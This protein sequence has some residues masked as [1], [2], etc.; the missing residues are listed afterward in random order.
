MR[1]SR[2]W[3]RGAFLISATLVAGLLYALP[4]DAAGKPYTSP[5]P[6]REK[7]VAGSTYKPVVNPS[8]P[9]GKA[10]QPAAPV[11]PT[12]SIVD[13]ALPGA[14]ER[15]LGLDGPVQAGNLPLSVASP[16]GLAR[17]RIESFD[18]ATTATAGIDGVLLRV[19]RS[20]GLSG[21]TNVELIAD[22]KP[23]RWA[24]GGDWAS[25]LRLWLVPECA[26]TSPGAPG[27]QATLLPTVNNP[28]TGTATATVPVEGLAV[29][30]SSIGGALA[31]SDGSAITSGGA[32]VALAA[33][34][35][36][37]AG[38]Y[39]ASTLSPSATW[40][41]GG[42]SGDF[43]W[44][45]PI[46]V[47]P[48]LGG[49]TPPIVLNY[50]S[51]SV[52]GRMA[53]AN[54]QA[55]WIG[56]GFEWNPGSIERRYNSCAEDMDNGANN[57]TKTGDQCWETDNASLSLSGHAG[58][59]LK[60]GSNPNL[61]HLRNDDGTK[62]EHKT[63]GSNGDNDGEW[64]VATTP[65]GT[66]YWFGS[67]AAANSTLTSPVFGNNAGEPCHQTAF[68]DSSC[69]QA[70]RWQLDYVVDLRGNTMTYSYAKETN[71]YGRNNDKND[72]VVYDRAGY[73]TSIQYGTHTGVTGSAPFQVL[74][75]VSD[76]CLAANC[77]NHA[78]TTAWPDI[79]GDQECTASP[80]K[81]TQL[82]PSF[83]TTK[84]LTGIKTQVWGGSAYRDVESWTLTQSFPDPT[85][86]VSPA[87]WLDKISHSGLVGMTTTVPDIT[88]VG[89]YLPNRVDTNN[90]QY[91]AMN[92]FRIKTVN[93]ESGGKLDVT[94]SAPDCVKGSR[95][96][97]TAHLENNTYRCYP[98][99]W[100]PA[101]QTNPIT[102]FF[103]KY[104]VT[105]VVEA[106]LTGSSTRVLTHYDYVGDPA[107]HY[108]DDDGF[109]KKDYK[110]WSIWRGYGTVQVTKGDPGEQ[111]RTETRF[112]RGM[113][114][115]YLPSGTR[116][117]QLPAIATGNVPA[118]ND[119]DAFAGMTRESITNNGPGG[120]EVSAEVTEPWQSA[121]TATRTINGSTVN[122]R[123]TGTLA[124]HTR[125]TLDGGRGTRTTSTVNVLDA[126]GAITE[127]EDRGDDAVTG[128]EKCTLTDYLRN[129]G[130][131]LLT[132]TSRVR[133]FSTNCTRA[134]GPANQLT[135]ADVISEKRTSYDGQAWNVVPTL[136]DVTKSESLKAYN[137]GNP[138]FI[139]DSSSTRDSYGRVLDS[140]DVRGQ[141]TS[142]AYTPAT[143]GPVTSMTETNPLGWVKSTTFE[144]AW[145]VT[146]STT[147][148][149]GRKVDLAYDGLGR[150][151]NVWM[152]GRDKATQT[153]NLVYDY[154]IRNN[155]VT[156]LTTK[157]L[158]ASGGYITSYKLMDNLM[159]IRQTQEPD[160]AGG[161]SAVV[162][163]TYYDSAG[164]VFKTHDAYLASDANHQPVAPSTNLFLPTDTIPAQKEMVF[165]G[166]GRQIAQISKVNVPPASPGGTEK[167]RVT[168]VYGGDRTDTIQ[169]TGGTASSVLTDGLGRQVEMRQYHSGVTP[170]YNTP[171]S[172]YDSTKYLYD[173]KDQLK[174]V[175]D[176]SG[177]NWVY[178]YDMRGHQTISDDPDKGHIV[179]N[180]NDFGDIASTTDGRNFTIAYTYD[181]VGRK[182]SL[183]DGSDTGPKRAEWIYDT[184]SN[185]TSVKGQLVKTIRY[186]GTDQY[187]KEHVGYTVDYKP[188]SVKFTI[189]G[190]QIGLAGTYSY[191]YT[192]NQDG[193]QNTTRLPAMG[194]LG[195]ETLTNGYNS[196]GK[197]TTL[198][199][200]LGSTYVTGTDYTSF[201]ELAAQHLR[202]NAG[203]LVDVTRTYETDTRRLAQIWTTRATSPT[204]VA[205]V[206]FSYDAVGDVTKIADVNAGDT[207]CFQTDYLQRLSEAW[208]PANGDCSVAP[209]ST[210][211][212]GP[213]A[214]WNSYQYDT[215]GSRTQ[216][217]EHSTPNG[218]RTT[219]YTIP[220]GK[221][222]LD[223]T[224]AVDGTGTKTAAYTY[225]ASG[226]TLT[227]PTA[228][229]G[230]Q[231]LTWDAEG[232]LAT[233]QD[234]TGTTSYVYDV[235]G[236]R[237]VRVDPTGKTLYLP[238]QELRYANATSVKT[239]T[240]YYSSSDVTV[241]MRTSAGVTW[242]AADHHGT[243]QISI[244]AVGQATSIRR[245]TPFGALR[246]TTGTW[247]SAMDKG[248]VGGT[249]DNTGLTH[250]GAREYDTLIGRFISVDPVM[251]N[252]DPQQMHGYAYAN[253][254]PATAIDANGMWPSFLD[255]AVNKVTQ[256]VSQVTSSVTNAVTAGAKWVYNNAG[257]ISTVLSVAAVVCTVI[258]PLQAAAPFLG[259]AAEVFNAIDTIHTCS[260]GISLDCAAGVAGMIPGGRAL[261][262][263]AKE[264]KAAKKALNAAEEAEDIAKAE[265]AAAK[266][267]RGA[268]GPSCRIRPHSFDPATP[269]LMADGTVKPIASIRAGDKV[270]T[271]DPKTKQTTTRE[272]T[273]LHYNKDWDLTDLTITISGGM[274]PA[275]SGVAHTVKTTWYHP[276]WDI[277]AKKWVHASE[278]RLGD[279]LL[280]YDNKIATVTGSL[281]YIGENWMNDLTVAQIHTFYI[282]V[283]GTPV[284]VHNRYADDDGAPWWDTGDDDVDEPYGQ[285]ADDD[286]PREQKMQRG[287]NRASNRKVRWEMQ[288]A[289]LDPNDPEQREQVHR[290]IGDRKLDDNANVDRDELREA[291]DDVDCDGT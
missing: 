111:T 238:G 15:Q 156:V 135:D 16:S 8:V 166:A 291:I 121:P 86:S 175:T 177:L 72:A 13:V 117:V 280:T 268:R 94:Y 83:W 82:S 84:R 281:S 252:K 201:N 159:R 1:L 221:H 138:T 120:A 19:S 21:R 23:F 50:S 199:T 63:G 140:Y 47:P 168:T 171:A 36:G 266:A 98:V 113:H 26:M 9:T 131:N 247:P 163:D 87:L 29:T 263:A 162:T 49:P 25:R 157:R 90:D 243:A 217:V 88:F 129:T 277:T 74:F 69:T 182:T 154:L 200:S 109:I 92:K 61:W 151:T 100:I 224:S 251:D 172:G 225:D 75:T 81:D 195:L 76:R 123:F 22:Y 106:D 79:P 30:Q 149:N 180:Y 45:Y 66:Q 245:E 64:W 228:S 269:V 80:C 91:P 124:K 6:Q 264:A 108:A 254:A 271:T 187:I 152:P 189:P 206:R 216:L 167:W 161:T 169:P 227:R 53:N 78:D 193:T 262:V 127:T 208:T 126:Y 93:S 56:E 158:N 42:N 192:Y 188:T 54:N 190:T 242:L 35:S 4:A 178:Q 212:G 279:Q 118:V 235:D 282:V 222:R 32:L 136:G 234:G 272:V 148:V 181:A 95:M 289:G 261:G 52:D 99:K 71:R 220:S 232:H 137:G 97:D 65:D 174:R 185:G 173:T 196:L 68:K 107:W 122:A 101:G 60:D 214:Y 55:S 233:A 85:D 33:A 231:T 203:S 128:D 205:D 236:N 287:D 284:L 265:R 114:G 184:L 34:A 3:R 274:G 62:V 246:Q 283:D 241:A 249:N 153:P 44:S 209:A 259:A 146:L 145:N 176:Q 215:A 278:I 46:R 73:L 147:D 2:F 239:C 58:E 207:Q 96:P 255:K 230:T 179:T 20:D 141:K 275:D 12:A 191:V 139:T 89:V 133:T 18:R 186:V 144:P 165:D 164:R 48:S 150:L 57:T 103:H 244:N 116:N 204:T 67:N 11:W 43:S 170:A 132:P 142:T 213:A 102:D 223:G 160:G 237:L 105:D 258:P 226:N 27:C 31:T 24:Y 119:E 130:I 14:R 39:S 110:T 70:Y 38:D 273:A 288:R 183:R 267:D 51:S 285:Y 7:P 155:A 17:A 41:A 250:L 276:F 270:M 253:N 210:T 286:S 256:A 197:Q 143:G 229:S 77:S 5:K 112:F 194:D 198:S 290:G 260:E 202:N 10:F 248:F 115:D 28:R 104:L 211:L 257:T 240:R 125:T 218:V 40:N 37:P 219:T 134:K 59:L